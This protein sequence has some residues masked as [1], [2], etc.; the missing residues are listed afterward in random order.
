M[1]GRKIIESENYKYFGAILDKNLNLQSHID[2]RHKKAAYWIKL[3]ERIC[4]DINLAVAD[5]MQK[6]M[7]FPLFL[8][9]SNIHISTSVPQKT[10]IE[11]LQHCALKIT[12][13]QHSAIAF[14][15]IKMS[16]ISPVQMQCSNVLADSHRTCLRIIS[17]S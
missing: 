7:V 11:K 14:P 13:G 4:I 9:C 17:V 2:N 15:A 5:T 16:K 6:V 3:Q 12:N 10:R 8:Y 1:N